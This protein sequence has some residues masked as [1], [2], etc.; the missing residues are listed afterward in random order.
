[1]N[2][3]IDEGE[4]ASNEIIDKKSTTIKLLRSNLSCF[5]GDAIFINTI[6]ADSFIITGTRLKLR[7]VESKDEKI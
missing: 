3:E 2:N 7:K 5:L 1:M 6:L 4:E